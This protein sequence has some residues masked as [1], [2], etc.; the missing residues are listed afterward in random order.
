[1]KVDIDQLYAD[2]NDLL[3]RN[4]EGRSHTV[5]LIAELQ[6]TAGRVLS[7]TGDSTG[8]SGKPTSRPPAAASIAAVDLLAHIESGVWQHDADLRDAL[9]AHLNYDRTWTQALSA[10]PGLA[11]RLPNAEQHP[12]AACLARAVRS[13]RNTARVH[14]GHIAPMATLEAPCPYCKEQSLIVRSD[15]SSDVV[16]TT[17][18][19][20]DERGEQPRWTRQTW[21]LLLTGR[22]TA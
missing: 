9:D 13:W 11:N 8:R 16:C 20:E 19:C 5:G 6:F 1:M 10:L 15:A 7:A 18:G 12:L 17:A 21:T 22:N 14:L 2:V 4:T 3:A